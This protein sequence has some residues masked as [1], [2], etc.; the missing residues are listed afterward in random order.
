MNTK[1]GGFLELIIFIL[2]ALLIMKY[3]DI[4]I[5]EVIYWFK[6]FFASVLR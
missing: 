4:T 3:F 6:S 1:Q 5:S 2:V